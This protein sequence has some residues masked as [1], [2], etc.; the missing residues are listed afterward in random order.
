MKIECLKEKLK[1]TISLAEKVTSKTTPLAVLGAILLEAKNNFLYIRATNLDVGVEFTIPADVKEEGIVAVSGAVLSS[2]LA[3]LSGK[4]TISL[5]LKNKNLFLETEHSTIVIKSYQS[6]D[7]PTLPT[8]KKGESFSLSASKL[9]SGIRSVW[10][11]SAGS[12]IKPEMSSVYIYPED[13]Q[14]VF[15]ATDSFRLA[16]KKI[17][18]QKPSDFTGVIIPVKNAQEI[19]RVFEEKEGD[20]AVMFNENQA[21]FY[22][23]EVYFTSRIVHG[24][25]PDY[26]QIVPKSHTTEAV[27]LKQ[28]ILDTLKMATIFSDKFNKITI[29]VNPNKKQLIITAQNEHGGH[30]TS[31][32]AMISGESIKMNF[33]HRYIMDCFQSISSDS[34]IFEFD[35]PQ[36]PLVIKGVGENSFSALVMPTNI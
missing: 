31:V 28:D 7:F 8:V 9:V 35:G 24:V 14:I 16:E 26:K 21:S 25:F 6:D 18:P 29:D 12:D 2:T 19:I 32:P 23:D 30:T 34:I 4:N 27:L 5:E 36:K 3:N 22:S 20:V 11:S 1:K 10:Y 13:D 33:N 15:V 17:K